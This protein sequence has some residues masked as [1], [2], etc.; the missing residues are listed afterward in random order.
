MLIGVGGIGG[1]WIRRFLPVHKDRVRISAIVDIVPE[2]LREAGDLL[3]LPH[4]ERHATMSEGFAHADV[5]FCV[6]A[7]PPWHHREAILGAMSRRLPVLSEKPVS[8]KL[9][10]VREIADAVTKADTKVAIIQNYRFTPRMQAFRTALKSGQL[11]R[12]QHLVVRFQADYRVFGSW[13]SKLGLSNFRHEMDDPLLIDAAIHHLDMIRNLTGG[14][15]RTISGV[16]WNPPWGSFAGFSSGLYL[17]S[18]DNGTQAMYEGNLSGA[19]H[20]NTWHHEYY[21]AE[22]ELGS[23][24]LGADDVLMLEKAGKP[25]KRIP[26]N[27]TQFYG[28]QQIISDFLDW[29]DGGKA[30]ETVFD[31]NLK[32]MAMVFAAVEAGKSGNTVNVADFLPA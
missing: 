6:V 20:Q 23:L 27:E 9:S 19:G 31:D 10:E 5:D 8:D 2:V 30:P 22:C 26:I 32:S 17:C 4:S 25:V 14:D 28:H 1:A 16:G 24:S 18:M 15:C 29:L 11:G 7:V 21:R 13:G 12:L 3:N